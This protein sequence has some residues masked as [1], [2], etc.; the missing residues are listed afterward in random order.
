MKKLILSSVFALFATQVNA[1]TSPL[2]DLGDVFT[3]TPYY[4]AS[5]ESYSETGDEVF[6]LTDTS[7]VSDDATVFLF[8]EFAGFANTN[9]LSIYDTATNT[10]LSF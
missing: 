3:G 1:A 8:F 6:R 9:T 7:G 5:M 4:S 10:F 2:D